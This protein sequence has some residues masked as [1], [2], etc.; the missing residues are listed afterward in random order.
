MRAYLEAAGQDAAAALIERAREDSAKY[1]KALQQS[2]LRRAAPAYVAI[3]FKFFLRTRRAV[4]EGQLTISADIQAF[5]YL[6]AQPATRSDS[7]WLGRFCHTFLVSARSSA[8]VTGVAV[9]RES[10]AIPCA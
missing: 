8:A 1:K 2:R 3:A 9:E 4:G 10:C 5:F 6:R 7:E